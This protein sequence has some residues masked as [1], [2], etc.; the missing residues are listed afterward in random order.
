M[1]K[2]RPSAPPGEWVLVRQS[3][4]TFVTGEGDRYRP[5]VVILVHTGSGVVGH[6]TALRPEDSP[7]A[8][9]AEIAGLFA[10][11]G[12]LE[13]T[14]RVRTSDAEIARCLR[15]A[16]PGL[17]VVVGATPE[18]TAALE[19]LGD[20]LTREAEAQPA[21]DDATVPVVGRFFEAAHRFHERR[22]WRHLSDA[23][24]LLLRA[25]S[26]GYEEGCL[27]VMG[28]GGQS[29]GLMLVQSLADLDRM[30][31]MAEHASDRLRGP[32]V[33]IVSVTFESPSAAPPTWRRLAREHRWPVA[34]G[35]FPSLQVVEPDAL[36]TPLRDADYELAI[37]VLDLVSALSAEHGAALA[38]P[39]EPLIARS[40]LD[41]AEIAVMAPPREI[42]A[43][44]VRGAG[45]S[46][47]RRRSR[48]HR[49]S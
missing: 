17:A 16:A 41:G 24:V 12:P 43:I 37:A 39:V 22:P 33:H 5:D 35:A 4:P 25:P 46:R 10:S 14:G 11:G 49:R 13:G 19:S 28:Q 18:A 26:R 34:R 21:L 48:G 31:V 7:D 6:V 9:V 1:K 42:V 38:D 15:E 3:M 44:P 23:D 8:A 47:G 30:L 2:R 32:G 36:L 27:L 29:Y 20:F 40:V 45:P